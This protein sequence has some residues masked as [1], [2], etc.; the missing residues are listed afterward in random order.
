MP[1]M[2]QMS[3]LLL[4][5]A[6]LLQGRDYSFVSRLLCFTALEDSIAVFD[7]TTCDDSNTTISYIFAAKVVTAGWS[8]G[9]EVLHR[10]PEIVLK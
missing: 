9:V 10:H 8:I 3:T 4:I 2:S 6:T 5:M 1:N 7:Q